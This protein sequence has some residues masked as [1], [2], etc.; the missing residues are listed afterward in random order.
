MIRR[1][2]KLKGGVTLRGQGYGSSPLAIKL[3]EGGTIIS[4]CGDDYAITVAGHSASLE[5]LAVY[6]TPY[7]GKC[8]SRCFKF[9]F[10][11]KQNIHVNGKA[12]S[13]CSSLKAKGGILIDADAK[14]VESIT[15]RNILLYWFMGGTSLTL[16]SQ[17]A[18]G[19][20]YASFENLRVRHAKVGIHLVAKDSQSFVNSNTFH[21]GAISGGIDDVAVLAEGPGKFV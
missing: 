4:Y 20:A 13:D 17:N 3:D 7:P 5:N 10:Q 11:R 14:L 21:D 16:R 15:M 12:N 9:Y 6:D 18:G 2:L 19:I 1:T 8:V